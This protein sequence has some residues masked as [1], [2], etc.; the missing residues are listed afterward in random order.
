MSAPAIVPPVEDFARS[1]SSPGPAVVIAPAAAPLRPQA[2]PVSAP[3]QT[4]SLPRGRDRNYER[5]EAEEKDQRR[6]RRNII[7][8]TVGIVLLLLMTLLLMKIAG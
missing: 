1:D 6:L 2:V 4:Q 5:A 3:G 7:A 8:A